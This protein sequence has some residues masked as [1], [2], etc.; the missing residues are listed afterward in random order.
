MKKDAWA[1]ALCGEAVISS[2][3]SST[4]PGSL[5][6]YNTSFAM[7]GQQVHRGPSARG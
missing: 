3:I 1:K 6:Y 4:S 2:I 5:S 7:M